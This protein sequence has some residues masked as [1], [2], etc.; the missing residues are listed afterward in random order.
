M[1]CMQMLYTGFQAG[2]RAAFP[3]ILASQISEGGEGGA[4]GLVLKWERGIRCWMENHALE[5]CPNFAPVRVL[6]D[7]AGAHAADQT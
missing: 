3:A 5:L 4:G 6:S 7:V 1:Q 2:S